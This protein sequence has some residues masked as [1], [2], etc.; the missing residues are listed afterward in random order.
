MELSIKE[1]AERTQLPPSTLRYYDKMGLMPMLKKT[2]YGT[3]KYSE[4]DI[5]WLELVCCLR[6]SGMSL[7]DIKAFM[8][9]CIQGSSSSEQ[10][11]ELLAQ[12]R[13]HIL[14]QMDLLHRS[15]ATVDYKLAHYNEIGIFHIDKP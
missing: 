13:E 15:L 7:D 1:V 14:K 8:M 4:T 3:R 10:R 9:L 5:S 2:D 6:D 12:H 11:R